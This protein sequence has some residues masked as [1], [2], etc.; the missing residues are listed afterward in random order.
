MILQ[1]FKSFIKYFLIKTKIVPEKVFDR[2]R[3]HWLRVVSN[4]SSMDIIQN[5]RAELS[6]VLEIS[7]NRWEEY[8]KEISYKNVHYPEFD[9]QKINNFSNTYDLIIIEHVLEHL[10]FPFKA[11]KNI[12]SLLNNNGYVLIITPFLVKIHNAPQDS[13]RWTETGIKYFLVECGFREENILTG[14]W[15][16]RS[17][18]QAN[19]NK[20][21]KYN[22]FIHSLANDPKYPIT[23]WA[24]AQK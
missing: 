11:T 21:I 2:T 12:Y 10:I 19:F 4:E 7:G 13:T 3:T 23:V 5:I 24:F 6:S 15:G 14:S 9:I 22:P 1:K 20:W 17:C 18:V 8:F 16:N